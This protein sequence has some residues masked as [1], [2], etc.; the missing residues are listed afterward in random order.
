MAVKKLQ[1]EER[2]KLKTERKREAILRS[3][4]AAFAEKGYHGTSMEDIADR[5]LMTKGSLYYYFKDK[6]E[7]LFACHDYSL[8]LVLDILDQVEAM[9]SSVDEKLGSLIAA[10]VD[11]MLDALQGSAMALDFSALSPELLEKII[12]KRDKFEGGMRKLIAKG[13]KDGTFRKVDGKLATFMIFGAINWV[14]KWYRSGGTYNAKNIG[15]A[16]ADMFVGSLKS[17]E[18]FQFELPEF[19][20]ERQDA[21]QPV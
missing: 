19:L 15:K 11:V 2:R 17:G 12:N 3:A 7:I 8:N 14:T 18:S 16:Y 6:E 13:I 20:G 10:H 1:P 5:L 4:A 21:V 9:D